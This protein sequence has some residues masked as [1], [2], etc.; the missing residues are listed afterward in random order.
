MITFDSSLLLGY[1]QGR[2]NVN[3]A[4][5]AANA[6]SSGSSK[7]AGASPPWEQTA[8]DKAAL[9]K[10]ILSGRGVIDKNGASGANGDDTYKQLFT[11]YSG[12]N[13]LS[14][15]LGSVNDK[16]A[17]EVELK[18]LQSVFDK[19]LSDVM[20]YTHD[21]KLD[22]VRVT[23][24]VSQTSLKTATGVARSAGSYVTKAVHTGDVDDAVAAFQGAVKFDLKV[25]N[26][27]KTSDFSFDL[28]EMGSTPRTMSK[29][30]D[31]VNGK[32][33]A[34]GLTTRFAVNRIPGEPQEVTI[35]DKKVKLEATKDSY[36]FQIDGSAAEKLTFSTS[37]TSAGI[38][39]TTRGGDPDPD[40]KTETDDAVYASTLTKFDGAS[41]AGAGQKVFTDNLQGTI[42]TVGKSVIGP[43]GSVY[44]SLR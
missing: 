28:S 22:G 2:A 11:L 34:A 15:L 9:A 16:T 21:M 42:D 3:L 39:V 27:G 43:D 8:P 12:L 38:Y 20:A 10:R 36:A 35:G 6:R 31:Y 5:G 14:A 32:L 37:N 19:G 30:R 1:Y 13:G 4:A 41:A 29:V 17:T 33:K 40:K 23:S 44:M 24:G 26:L 18:R 25:N 7:T